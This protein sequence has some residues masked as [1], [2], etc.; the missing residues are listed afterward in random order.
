MLAAASGDPVPNDSQWGRPVEFAGSFVKQQHR[1]AAGPKRGGEGLV[2][3][4]RQP[5]AGRA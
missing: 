2:G 1:G 4:D 5:A 3:D